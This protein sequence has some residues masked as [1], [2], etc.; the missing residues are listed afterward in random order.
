MCKWSVLCV[1]VCSWTLSSSWK[2]KLLQCR[3]NTFI[4]LKHKK[5]HFI[6]SHVAGDEDVLLTVSLQDDSCG[7]WSHTDVCFSLRV[8]AVARWPLVLV[9]LDGWGVTRWIFPEG[10]PPADQITDEHRQTSLCLEVRR[11]WT[12]ILMDPN[13]SLSSDSLIWF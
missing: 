3:S 8:S 5:H 6:I 4:S 13:S 10:L 9:V 11:T 2:N 1:P 12:L 7:S